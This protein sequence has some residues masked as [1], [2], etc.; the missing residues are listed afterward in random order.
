MAPQ[1]AE[2][3]NKLLA[4]AIFFAVFAIL[5]LIGAYAVWPGNF[6]GTPLSDMTSAMLL[7]AAVSLVLAI[8]GLEFLGALA[9]IALSD[10]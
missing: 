2:R 3:D 8:G 6:F 5:A 4:G 1:P 10:R 9:V 7:R